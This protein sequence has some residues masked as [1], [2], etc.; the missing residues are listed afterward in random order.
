MIVTVEWRRL[1]WVIAA[2]WLLSHAAIAGWNASASSWP[3]GTAVSCAVLVVVSFAVVD[4]TARTEPMTHGWV[5]VAV[6]AQAGT[7]AAVTPFLD[8]V[9]LWSYPTWYPGAFTPLLVCLVWTHHTRVALATAVGTC[10][11]MV[12]AITLDQGAVAL[13]WPSSWLLC[14]PP[15]LAIGGTL[16]VRGLLVE[17]SRTVATYSREEADALLEAARSTVRQ[18]VATR[19]RAHLEAAVGPLLADLAGGRGTR[20]VER[21]AR[22]CA[23]TEAALRDTLTAPRLPDGR[24]SASIRS[25]R[26]RGVTV[27]LMDGRSASDTTDPLTVLARELI[28]CVV[29]ALDHGQVTVR[30]DELGGSVTVVARG[31]GTAVAARAAADV[32]RWGAGRL[33]RVEIDLDPDGVLYVECVPPTA[34]TNAPVHASAAAALTRLRRSD[35]G[36]TQPD[37]PA[38]HATPRRDRGLHTLEGAP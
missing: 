11:A 10:A 14:G 9:E 12:A 2:I 27:H 35:G 22:R 7:V 19:R 6:G 28:V 23:L 20:D 32:A 13:T 21:F 30:V 15:V 1:A 36:G 34:G 18:R 5:A 29:P 25:A 17:A 33:E 38:D 3:A 31:A 8:G 16:A 26:A 24:T 4:R 37:L